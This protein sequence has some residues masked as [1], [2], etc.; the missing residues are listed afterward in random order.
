M[1]K[2]YQIASVLY[3]VLKLVVPSDRVDDEIRAAVHAL[4]NVDGLPMPRLNSSENVPLKVDGSLI[5]ED[6]NRSVKDLL[7]WLL[8]VF[9]FQMANELR[10]ILFGNVHS[11]SG[12]YFKPAY[13]GEESFLKEVVT[14]IYLVMRKHVDQVAG[15]RK[16]KINFVEVRTFWHLFRSF[17][18]MWTFFILAFQAMLII[19]W[20]PSGS[21]TAFFD[22]DVFKSV[23][24]IFLTAAL[25]NF[26]QG[27]KSDRLK[28]LLKPWK[29]CISDHTVVDRYTLWLSQPS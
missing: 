17:D 4:Q 29:Q 11:A 12:G 18:R 20:S 3:D 21:V 9:G 6:G 2:H 14:P 23:L 1:A 27:R 10:A 13:Q 28:F 22:P 26:L 25:L 8:L 19:A 16:A 7:D 15:R 24:S 5:P